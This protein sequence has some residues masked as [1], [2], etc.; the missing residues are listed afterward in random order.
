MINS[1]ANLFIHVYSPWLRIGV[2]G[3]GGGVGFWERVGSGFKMGVVVNIGVGKGALLPRPS[4]VITARC[5]W[6]V[7]S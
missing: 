1:F 2:R 7:V 4:V 3:V 5:A 6:P